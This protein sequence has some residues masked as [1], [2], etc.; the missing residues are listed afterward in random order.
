MAE[1]RP[2]DANAL[3]EAIRKLPEWYGDDSY[4]SGINDVSRLID[5]APTIE[6]PFYQEAYQ[7]GY[8][9]RV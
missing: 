4:Y 3:K 2:I 5:L 9:E 7:T 6:Y 1:V 8:E